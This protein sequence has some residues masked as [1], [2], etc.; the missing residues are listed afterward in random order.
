MWISFLVLVFSLNTCLISNWNL[1]MTVRTG[2]FWPDPRISKKALM[3]TRIFISEECYNE[4]N[5]VCSATGL[6]KNNHPLLFEESPWQI[7][8]TIR[9]QLQSSKPPHVDSCDP[10]IY[11]HTGIDKGHQTGKQ[12]S[13]LLVTLSTDSPASLFISSPHQ[14][15]PVISTTK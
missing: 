4:N 10:S 2:L 8:L 6:F 5:F 3:S 13:L 1:G 15:K 14:C 7:T 12:D 11:W 9:C